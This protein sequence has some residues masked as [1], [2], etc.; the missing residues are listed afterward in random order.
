MPRRL[1]AIFFAHERNKDVTVTMQH[2]DDFWKLAEKH[3]PRY[4]EERD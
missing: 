2:G 4:R 1:E 3:D